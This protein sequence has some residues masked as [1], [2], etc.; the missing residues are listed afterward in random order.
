L[1]SNITNV[2][3]FWPWRSCWAG[4]PGA[5]RTCAATSRPPSPRPCSSWSCSSGSSW[6]APGS[7]SSLTGSRGQAEQVQVAAYSAGVR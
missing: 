1:G 4:S 2:G 7:R 5:A 6:S 3:S